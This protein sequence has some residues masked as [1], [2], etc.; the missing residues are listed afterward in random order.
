MSAEFIGDKKVSFEGESYNHLVRVCRAKVADHVEVLF[1]GEDALEVR[2]TEIG[3]KAAAGDIIR[4]RALP[5]LRRPYIQ[6]GFCFPKPA[7]FEAV[8]EKSVELGVHSI[9]PLFNEFSFYKSAR[10]IKDSKRE[11]WQKIVQAATEQSARGDLLQI[12]EPENLLSFAKKIN[13]DQGH[14]GLFLYEGDCAQGIQEG[15]ESLPS[16]KFEMVTA[17]VGSE[18]GFSVA[19]V[20]SLQNLG[21]LPLTMGAQILRAETACVSILSVIKYHFGQM[22]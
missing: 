1:G 11:R 7:V 19:E 13:P 5:K 10:D 22:N 17:L 21:L 18:G 12:K 8:I 14:R 3:K 6:L 15:L 20:E 2:L 4:R 9:Q 16:A